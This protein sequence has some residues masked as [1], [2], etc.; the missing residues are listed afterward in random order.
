MTTTTAAARALV[1]LGTSEEPIYQA[2]AGELAR[3][4]ARGL[5]VDVGCGTGRFRAAAAGIARDYIGVDV[6]RHR[7]L[8]AG[9]AFVAADLDREPIPLASALA[10]IVVAIET[11]EHLENPRGFCRELSRILK[12]G[13]WLVITTPNQCS[14]LSLASLVVRGRFAAFPD[15]S[16]PVHCTALLPNDLVRLAC[17]CGL[18]DPTVAF[19]AS[20][21]IPLT[22]RH[23]PRFLSRLFPQAL[24]DNVLL[25]ARKHA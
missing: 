5:V 13:G 4:G 10:D 16:Y 18:S 23:Y 1:T 7:G 15:S 14:L 20:G 12:P 3:R 8:E 21:R 22:P 2:A 11:I 24:S 17:E 9:A 6:V 25:V 19:T